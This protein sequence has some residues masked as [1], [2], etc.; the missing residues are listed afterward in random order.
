VRVLLLTPRFYGIENK[1]KTAFEE[2]NYEVTWIE[3]KTL[4]LD[5]HSPASKLRFLRRIYFSICSPRERYLKKELRKIQNSHFDL[6]FA[7]NGGVVCRYLFERLKQGNP[8]VKSLVFFWDSFAKFDW[9]A[10]LKLFNRAFTFDPDD[11]LRQHLEYKPNFYLKPGFKQDHAIE[12]DLFFVGKFSAS[13]L[14]ILDKLT[15]RSNSENIASFIKLY[16]AYKIF[17]HKALVYGFF[18]KI[19]FKNSWI[20]DYI[21][22][23]EAVEGILKRNFLINKSLTYDEVQADF[24]K[25]NVIL[26]LPYRKQAGYTHRL[27]E[28]LATGKKIITTDSNILKAAFYNSDQI[29][30]LNELEP[31]FDF[32]WMKERRTFQSNENFKNLELSIWLKSFFN[33]EPVSF[34]G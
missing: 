21:I 8:A 20:K 30:I 4:L 19:N 13:R 31:D 11:S 23:Y 32:R 7:I 28:A 5:Y 14:L 18:K 26:D 29:H 6:L 12:H 10:E 9:S 1:I 16:P 24:L 34:R 17:P 15:G 33:E 27:I 25:S 3:N 2:L 22:S